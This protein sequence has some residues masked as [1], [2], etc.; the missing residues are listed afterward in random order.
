M[1]EDEPAVVVAYV[2][3]KEV[4]YSWHRSFVEMIGHDMANH[5]R[6]IRGGYIAMHYGTDGLVAARNEAVR[7]FLDEAKA[8]WLFWVDTDMGF[9]PDTIDRLL[10]AADPAERPIVGALAFSQ[11]EVGQDGM[12][13]YHTKPTPTILDWVHSGDQAGFAARWDYPPDAVVQCA[14][15]GSAVILIHRSVFERIAAHPD[16]GGDNW[17]GRRPNPSTGQVFGEDLSFCLRAGALGIPVYVHTGVRTSHLKPQ[18]VGEESYRAVTPPPPATEPTAVIVP[19]MNRPQN[20]EP[21][22]RSLRASTGLATVYAFVGPDDAATWQAWRDAGAVVVECEEVS[23]AEKVNLGYRSTSEPWLFIVGD[24][25]KFHPGWLDH[26]QF[27]ARTGAKVIGVNDLGNPRT[28]AGEHA[29]H[30]LI[31]REYV[32]TVGASWDGPGNVCHEG[33]RHWYV[34]DEI[35]TAAKQ[36]GV[37]RMAMGSIV[38]HMH[39]LFKKGAD[40]PVYALGQSFAEAD[41]EVFAKRLEAN[42]E[43]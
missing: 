30:L 16:M 8:D 39:P 3:D 29:A 19:V 31:S 2:H 7:T 10:A 25:V 41:A 22:M 1:T 14:G 27:A 34:D 6:F 37:W 38:E 32:D 40:D 43:G 15:T 11:R 24:D 18:W 42:R 4:A 20:A 23:F 5:G 33:F 21:F 36:R 28:L 12:G 35:V 13:G 17:Y 9:E 26:A